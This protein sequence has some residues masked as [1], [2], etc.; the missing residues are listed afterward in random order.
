MEKTEQIKEKFLD[1]Y[2]SRDAVRKYSTGTA[3]FGINY[4]LQHDYARVYVNAVDSYLQTSP[5]RPIRLLEFGCGGG[6]NIICPGCR[7]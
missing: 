5:A 6:M 1:E 2:D 4:L 3:G 7:C